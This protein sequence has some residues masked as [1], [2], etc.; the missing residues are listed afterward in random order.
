MT[1]PQAR[2]LSYVSEDR[3]APYIHDRHRSDHGVYACR[4]RCAV[5]AANRVIRWSTA[6]AVVG[7]ADNEHEPARLH[8]DIDRVGARSL[9]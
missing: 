9:P 1:Y 3:L 8:R 4:W 6:G 7:L 5:S 2:G